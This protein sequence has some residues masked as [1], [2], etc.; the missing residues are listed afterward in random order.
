[1]SKP[2]LADQV[3]ALMDGVVAPEEFQRVADEVKALQEVLGKIAVEAKPS[4]AQAFD[5][6]AMWFSVGW[7]AAAKIA[8]AAL[9]APPTGTTDE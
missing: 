3:L 4:D 5:T 7:N 6:G 1:M 8:R 2:T 9:D